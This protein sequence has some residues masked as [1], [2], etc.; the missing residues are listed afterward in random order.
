MLLP[1]GNVDFPMRNQDSPMK[2]V[3]FT[4]HFNDPRAPWCFIAPKRMDINPILR[5]LFLHYYC[6]TLF[7]YY[8][9]IIWLSPLLFHDWTTVISL[10]C[11]IMSF[12]SLCYF[13][14][15]HGVSVYPVLTIKTNIYIYIITI[16]FL[17]SYPVLIQWLSHYYL[18]TIPW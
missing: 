9:I 13:M 11:H 12:L 18:I 5:Y 2:H 8:V 14:D 10:L 6:H 7:H 1:I 4:C 15:F 17:E 3:V 16:L